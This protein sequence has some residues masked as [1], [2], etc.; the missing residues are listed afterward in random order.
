VAMNRLMTSRPAL[1]GAL[2]VDLSD[3]ARLEDEPLLVAVRSRPDAHHRAGSPALNDECA[4]L[5]AFPTEAYPGAWP[6]ELRLL[7]RQ[8]TP[9]RGPFRLMRFPFRPSAEP[10]TEGG[11]AP[12]LPEHAAPPS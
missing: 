8:G 10:S 7:G 3:C 5:E 2:P 12:T 11:A 1:S 9:L 6:G 4:A